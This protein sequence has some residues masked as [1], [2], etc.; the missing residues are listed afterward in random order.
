MYGAKQIILL[1]M[2]YG[3]LGRIAKQA[4]CLR[5]TP[6][7][8][9][10]KTRARRKSL[11]AFAPRA[12]GERDPAIAYSEEEIRAAIAAEV[13]LWGG[14]RIAIYGYRDSG[15]SRQWGLCTHDSWVNPYLLG[16][17]FPAGYSVEQQT[18]IE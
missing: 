11:C 17:R 3:V 1:G 7:A 16:R 6:D 12:S 10:G 13:L 5:Q 14:D 2:S 15:S 18:R 4:L 9:G 8:G